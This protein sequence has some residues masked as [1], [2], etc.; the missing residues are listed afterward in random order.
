MM[1]ALDDEDRID[2]DVAQML[3]GALRRGGAGAER[4][5]LVEP[6]G[7]EPEAPRLRGGELQPGPPNTPAALMATSSERLG[8]MPRTS[9]RMAESTSAAAT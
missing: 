8:T 9:T 2:L 6:L 7:A 1:R 4:L 5:A 3:D